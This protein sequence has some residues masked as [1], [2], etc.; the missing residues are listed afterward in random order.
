MV[1]HC[2][3]IS[4]RAGGLGG[5][6]IYSSHLDDN[7]HWEAPVNLG[8]SINTP[9]NEQSPFIHPDNQTLYFSSDGWVG[10]GGYDLFVS[11]RKDDGCWGKPVN[12]GYPI[13]TQKDEIGL[14]VNARGNKAY[15]SSSRKEGRGLDIYSFDLYKEAQPIPVSYMKGTVFDSETNQKLS[16]HFELIDLH[17]ENSSTRLFLARLQVHFSLRFLLIRNMP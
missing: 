10:M 3:F 14:F 6:D 15:F 4:N 2:N 7:G 17:M 1:V 16:A 9:F 11:R 13:N 8:D 5:F 12:L